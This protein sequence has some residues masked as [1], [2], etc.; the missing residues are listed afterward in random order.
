[1]SNFYNEA[2]LNFAAILKEFE[3]LAVEIFSPFNPGIEST[4]D[5]EILKA[6]SR[7]G[8]AV[9]PNYYSREYCESICKEMDELYLR[10]KDEVWSDTEN[11][12]HRIYGANLISSK[13]KKFY[14]DNR[15]NN[16]LQAHEKRQYG[17][18]FTLGGKLEYKNNNLGS[19][20]GWH[21][22]SSVFKQTK[23]IMYLTDV[24]NNNGPFQYIPKS[25]LRKSIYFSALKTKNNLTKRRYSE[26][27]VKNLT[28]KENEI[29]TFTGNAG[30]LILVDTRGIHRGKPI[31]DGLRYSL[32]NYN[33][34]SSI[35]PEHIKKVM[36]SPK[37]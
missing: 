26:E 25:H 19:G 23:A 18:G 12:D 20:G 31:E 32:T 11:S 35:I 9:I 34:V 8:Y 3:N 30:T 37:I 21:R 15:I 28:S 6:I 33:W 24:E 22:D 17:I 13:I 5:L 1:M 10:Y 2:R 4:K 7:N 16:I 27:D 36:V 14:E 29:K